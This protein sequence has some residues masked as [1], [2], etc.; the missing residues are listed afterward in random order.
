MGCLGLLLGCVSIQQLADTA[1]E[2]L[3]KESVGYQ[4]FTEVVQNEDESP[5]LRLHTWTKELT[6][7]DSTV[8]NI[9][10]KIGDN[11]EKRDAASNELDLLKQ[12]L[13]LIF[14]RH[15]NASIVVPSWMV[16]DAYKD[17]ETITT[18]LQSLQTHYTKLY[19]ANTN[20]IDIHIQVAINEK[21]MDTQPPCKEII[22]SATTLDPNKEFCL[23]AADQRCGHK[24]N[25]DCVQKLVQA[26]VSERYS[27]SM[28]VDSKW[29][30]VG[31]T[32]GNY[33]HQEVLT[34]KLWLSDIST[35]DLGTFITR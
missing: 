19:T 15:L 14:N 27:G 33:R 11:R 20:A 6:T 29:H 16:K 9:I 25:L 21:I 30:M 5:A 17:A 32:K 35:C 7:L 3:D 13:D 28:C 10:E 12:K 31:N 4:G 23:K 24:M 34:P 8:E 18:R 2:N 1:R 26:H 22:H